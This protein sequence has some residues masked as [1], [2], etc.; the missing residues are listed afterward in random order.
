MQ[1]EPNRRAETGAF[2]LRALA[3]R[4]GR[5]VFWGA[6]GANRGEEGGDVGPIEGFR[7]GEVAGQCGVEVVEVLYGEGLAERVGAGG[8][9]E[10]VGEAVIRENGDARGF[11]AGELAVGAVAETAFFRAGVGGLYRS[12]RMAWFELVA[13]CSL[14]RGC[15]TT[16]QNAG[17]WIPR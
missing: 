4:G 7:L 16:A 14:S 13:A 17:R 10:G 5:W 11:A 12:G 9:L 2:V 8:R 6:A 3:Q 15:G 1:R